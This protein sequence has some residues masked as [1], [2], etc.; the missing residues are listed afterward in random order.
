MHMLD[1]DCTL[2]TTLV[3]AMSATQGARKYQEDTALFWDEQRACVALREANIDLPTLS[4]GEVVAVL[5]DGMGGH[6]GG[7]TAS[8]LA[9]ESFL[10][11]FLANSNDV[12]DR[13]LDALNA[14]NR[15]L[16]DKVAARPMFH[17]MGTTLIGVAV[18]DSEL[19]WISVGDSLLYLW[20]RGE[21]ARLNE[22]HSMA[23]EID[24]LV[25]AGKMSAEA[26]ANDPRR[27]YLRAAITGDEIEMI[28]L[29]LKPLELAPGDVVIVASDGIHTLDEAEIASIIAKHI[30]D[31]PASITDALV[32]AIDAIGNR[33]QDNTT[34]VAIAVREAA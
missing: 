22:D 34:V 3:S 16:A 9:A 20:R 33:H 6:V 32:N 23:P 21:L 17:G 8:R 11:V 14:A 7:A 28:D 4:S 2:S 27:H 25:A 10:A 29:A 24:R 5:G 12:S 19:S 1:E 30:A 18:R 26:G 13:L 31:G 15:A